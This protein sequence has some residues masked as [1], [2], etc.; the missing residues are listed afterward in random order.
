M[1]VR[2]VIFSFVLSVISYSQQVNLESFIKADRDA[3]IKK[4]IDDE[5]KIVGFEI[6]VVDPIQSSVIS[7]WG[8][9]ALRILTDDI[10]TDVYISFAAD[11]PDFNEA[12]YF[13]GTAGMYNIS[14]LPQSSKTFISNY[15]IN[16]HRSITSIPIPMNPEMKRKL[17]FQINEFY[18][19]RVKLNKY[20]FYGQNCTSF[21]FHFLN[22]IGLIEKNKS[23]NFPSRAYQVG[24]ESGLT[25]IPSYKYLDAKKVNFE[26]RS[27]LDKR[28]IFNISR[29]VNPNLYD[30]D[31]SKNHFHEYIK[32]IMSSYN[33]SEIKEYCAM[34]FRYLPQS[35][36][37]FS[38]KYES[39][40]LVLP[41]AN[42]FKI[43][44]SSNRIDS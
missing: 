31:F 21:L 29:K 36:V 13:R 41:S 3:I 32:I 37:V 9:T 2:L 34:V 24:L 40:N 6:V 5:S 17:L 15:F 35:Q 43:L 39:T 18:F 1:G 25:F 22:K 19:G 10:N 42:I 7:G 20:L 44:C 27:P 16:E 23:T 12:S 38:M 30:L 33:S 4:V 14:M 26:T 28:L 11:I 8:H